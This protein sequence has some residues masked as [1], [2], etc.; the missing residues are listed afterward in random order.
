MHAVS[1]PRE[2]NPIKQK[3]DELNRQ[4]VSAKGDH[5]LRHTEK[6]WF[7]FRMLTIEHKTGLDK[8]HLD[9]LYAVLVD[10]LTP[11]GRRARK[12]TFKQA[13]AEFNAI[14]AQQ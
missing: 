4:I 13:Y 10:P 12:A 11:Y 7:L 6:D 5:L 2:A 9:R 3:I 1:T 14:R 8:N